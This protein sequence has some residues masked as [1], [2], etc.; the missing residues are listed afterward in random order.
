MPIKVVLFTSSEYFK[1]ILLLNESLSSIEMPKYKVRVFEHFLD[2]LYRRNIA[3]ID[4]VGLLG[5]NVI[6]KDLH[7]SGLFRYTLSEIEM[8]INSS[9]LK[10]VLRQA[11][12][13]SSK[14]L[15][16]VGV[17]YINQMDKNGNVIVD[18]IESL[19]IHCE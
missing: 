6:A 7:D 19:V 9:S 18:L 16:A 12:E 1:T 17:K 13:I 8:R 11:H 5:L 2:Y 14:E 3:N 15:R 10:Y 4:M